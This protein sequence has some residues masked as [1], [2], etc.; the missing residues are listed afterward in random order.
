MDYRRYGDSIMKRL[1]KITERVSQLRKAARRAIWKSQVKL[2]RK[3][4]GM[5]IQEFQKG[6]LVW[7]FDKLAIM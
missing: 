6:D 4:E 1:L 3:F 2:N 5:K 7:Y